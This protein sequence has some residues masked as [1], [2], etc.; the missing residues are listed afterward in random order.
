MSENNTPDYIKLAQAHALYN[1]VAINT[2]DGT[3]FAYVD[4]LKLSDKEKWLAAIAQVVDAHPPLDLEEICGAKDEWANRVCTMPKG[5]KKEHGRRCE[6]WKVIGSG[7]KS[8]QCQSTEGHSRRH[9][10]SNVFSWSNDEPNV[11]QHA[12]V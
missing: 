8:Y 11:F 3:P 7:L 12:V 5:H 2:P 1:I 10:Y 6:S 4:F 9:V